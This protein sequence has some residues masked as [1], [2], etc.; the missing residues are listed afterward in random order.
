LHPSLRASA[1]LPTR[2]GESSASNA[3]LTSGSAGGLVR[4]GGVSA[5][6]FFFRRAIV[7]RNRRCIARRLAPAPPTAG[8]DLGGIPASRCRLVVTVRP[9][10]T[11]T[12]QA[13]AP[14]LLC[15]ATL[16]QRTGL[17]P[18]RGIT[19]FPDQPQD[20]TPDRQNGD[21]PR[22]EKQENH[23]RRLMHDA[24]PCCRWATSQQKIGA[25][26]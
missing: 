14:A 10:L 9:H 4:R 13:L 26:L 16:P 25:G 1:I 5:S 8:D 7:R 17:Q 11:R 6:L 18:P 3:A 20:K 23:P 2:S 22:H 21:L 12:R 19:K 24:A 15:S